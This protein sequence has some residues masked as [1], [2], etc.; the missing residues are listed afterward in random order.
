MWEIQKS[1]TDENASAMEMIA[2]LPKDHRHI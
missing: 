1:N 2:I